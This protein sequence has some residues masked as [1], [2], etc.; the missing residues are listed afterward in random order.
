VVQE[1]DTRIALL[2][3]VAAGLG[4]SVVSASMMR[5]PRDGVVFRE[6]AD[7]R[8]RAQLVALSFARPSPRATELLRL[9]LAESR[10][11]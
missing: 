11:R 3:L 8:L 2:G 1:T 5:I 7:F 4:I 6:L 9:A 10:K